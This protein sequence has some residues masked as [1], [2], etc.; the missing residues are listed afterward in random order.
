MQLFTDKLDDLYK[1]IPQE[2]FP[3]DY[4]GKAEPVSEL[5]SKND[6]I[7]KYLSTIL[8]ILIWKWKGCVVMS[9]LSFFFRKT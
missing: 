3:S 8:R 9:S 5:T 1:I 2:C 4:G 6:F 7:C